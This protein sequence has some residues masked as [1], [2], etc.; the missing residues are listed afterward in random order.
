MTRIIDAAVM[1]CPPAARLVAI[2][3]VVTLQSIVGAKDVASFAQLVRVFDSRASATL[4]I[5]ALEIV[6]DQQVDVHQETTVNI[7]SAIGTTLSGASHHANRLFFLHTNSKLS[8]FG[9]TL[10]HAH[11]SGCQGGAISLSYGGELVLSC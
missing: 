2:A 6:F 7:V 10:S 3:A 1:R 4:S 11:C 5:T 9:V 8:L